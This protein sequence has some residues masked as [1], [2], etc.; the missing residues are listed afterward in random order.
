MGRRKTTTRKSASKAIKSLRAS[1]L[2]IH[3]LAKLGDYGVL[4]TLMLH[5]I[6]YA[7]SSYEWCRQKLAKYRAAN[8]IASFKAQVWLSPHDRHSGGR[9][10]SLHFLTEAGAELVYQATG[11][12][13]PRV[14]RSDPSAATLFHR[15]HVVKV[16]LAFDLAADA[17]SLSKPTWIMEQDLCPDAPEDLM[18]NRRKWL[19]HEFQNDSKV[20]TCQPDAACVIQIP[21]PESAV[22]NVGALFE[23][24]LSSEGL[25]QIQRKL[26]GYD[27]LLKC[28]K[29]KYWCGLD[30]LTVRVFWIVRSQRRIREIAQ[31]AR[32]E[33]VARL[34]RFT[35][36]ADCG[37]GILTGKV[38][39]DIDGGRF[40]IYQPT[41]L[42]NRLDNSL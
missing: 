22:T 3:C 34:F 23:I 14:L 38:W 11:N 32:G 19:Y 33:D 40:A 16:R 13:P 28:R 31:A 20:F 8:L 42:E 37:P 41:L 10:P 5:Q 2:D 4:D 24:D 27:A 36:F 29:F 6:A 9:V 25:Q 12:R 7:D 26:P 35:T 1:S 15:L 21:N 18:P 17:V 39:D 30:N